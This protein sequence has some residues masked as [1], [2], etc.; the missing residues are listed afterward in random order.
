MRKSRIW[1]SGNGFQHGLVKWNERMKDCELERW[2]GGCQR[3]IN[4]IGPFRRRLAKSNLTV[5]PCQR[6]LLEMERMQ[7]S[8]FRIIYK[9]IFQGVVSNKWDKVVWNENGNA[10]PPSMKKVRKL[11]AIMTKQY[12]FRMTFNRTRYVHG[13]PRCSARAVHAYLTLLAHMKMKLEYA[14]EPN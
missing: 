9:A 3:A 12:L 1:I 14:V 13:G 11:I 8:Y 5:Q 4:R 6:T 2:F 7:S 10:L